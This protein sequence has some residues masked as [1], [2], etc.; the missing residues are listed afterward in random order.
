MASGAFNIPPALAEGSVWVDLNSRPS[1]IWLFQTSAEQFSAV[2]A[3]NP[4]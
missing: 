1:E 2:T 3:A 4:A